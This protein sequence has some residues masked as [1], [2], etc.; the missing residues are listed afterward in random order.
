MVAR[1]VVLEVAGAPDDVLARAR[2]RLQGGLGWGDELMA[3]VTRVGA[4]PPDFLGRVTGRSFRLRTTWRPTFA[5]GHEAL[6]EV[7]GLVEPCATGTRIR[8]I[9]RPRKIMYWSW[10]LLAGPA[11]IAV[12]R[13][14]V[15][16]EL[17]IVP[18][19]IGAYW[20]TVVSRDVALTAAGLQALFD[21]AG[22]PQ[23]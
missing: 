23:S 3:P 15:T 8:A 11:A 9:I 1:H 4:G 5:R 17:L 22:P 21:A 10:A 2:C 12:V 18:A 13:R 7:L 6:I 14:E 16:P 19:L 20:L